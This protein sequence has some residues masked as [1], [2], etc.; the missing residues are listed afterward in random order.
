MP[1]RLDYCRLIAI[2]MVLRPGDGDLH[3]FSPSSVGGFFWADQATSCTR[4]DSDL[5]AFRGANQLRAALL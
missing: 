2:D 3:G 5:A 1:A 4:G